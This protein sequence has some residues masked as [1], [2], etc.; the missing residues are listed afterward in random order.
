MNKEWIDKKSDINIVNSLR[1][2][3][4]TSHAMSS[5]LVNRDIHTFKQAMEFLKP[6]INK[7]YD[8]FLM[9]GIA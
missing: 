3:T 5:A 2:Q 1:S 8:P 7:L 6:D 9:K 4:N